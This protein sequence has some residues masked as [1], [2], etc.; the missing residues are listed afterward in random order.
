MVLADTHSLCFFQHLVAAGIPGLVPAPPHLCFCLRIAFSPL[1]VKSL[2]VSLLK[3]ARDCNR[4]Y[5][6]NDFSMS[7]SFTESQLQSPFLPLN[8][9]TFTDTGIRILY[10]WGPIF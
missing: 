6:D 3:D 9:T 2:S 7:R 1:N 10:H 8:K 4:A 5:Q